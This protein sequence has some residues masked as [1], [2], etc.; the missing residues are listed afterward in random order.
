[1]NRIFSQVE[2]STSLPLLFYFIV[3]NW[4]FFMVLMQPPVHPHPHT[5]VNFS[6]F[7]K[8]DTSLNETQWWSN[9]KQPSVYSVFSI[10]H[11]LPSLTVLT[12]VH[13]RRVTPRALTSFSKTRHAGGLELWWGTGS[14]WMYL[15]NRWGFN[16]LLDRIFGTKSWF[17]D[18]TIFSM[19]YI[20]LEIM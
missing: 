12:R 2:K 9:V 16:N 11:K 19:K 14:Q 13:G 20:Q 17:L 3:W 15:K 4:K 6:Q 10:K 7:L 18:F 8:T 1:M 5:L